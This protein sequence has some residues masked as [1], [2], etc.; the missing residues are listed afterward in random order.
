MKNEDINDYLKSSNTYTEWLNKG[1]VYLQEFVDIPFSKTEDY[2]RENLELE[3]RFFN[4]TQ[5]VNNMVIEPMM[6]DGKEGVGSMGD[7]TPI[8]AFSQVQRN[9]SDYFKQKFA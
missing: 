2:V 9:F 8:A 4:I 7:D 3:Q 5:E 6:K 1:L